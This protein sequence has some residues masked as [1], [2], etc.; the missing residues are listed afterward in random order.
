[1]PVYEKRA[2][3]FL[4]LLGF[5]SLIENKREKDILRI[6][7]LL[8]DAGLQFK[9]ASSSDVDF[10]CTTFSDCIVCSAKMLARDN[11]MPAALLALYAGWVALELLAKGILVRGA[12]T[13]GDLYHHE[14]TVFGPALIEAYELEAKHAQYPRIIASWK[15]QG[16]INTSLAIVRGTEW[17]VKNQPFRADFDGIYHLDIL[18]PFFVHQRPRSLRLKDSVK[19]ENLGAATTRLVTRICRARLRH[20]D[21]RISSKYEW[22]RSYLEDCCDR[23]GWDSPRFPRSRGYRRPAPAT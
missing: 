16:K 10:Q 20:K 4:D 12:M 13:V 17:F 9:E 3:L 23:F 5:R 11:Y 18:G 19:L 14:G 2:T 22:L 15:L 7:N 8:P 1:M 21:P 6:L